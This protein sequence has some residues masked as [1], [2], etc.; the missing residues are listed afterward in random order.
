MFLLLFVF[1]LSVTL[2]SEMGQTDAEWL[3]R[4]DDIQ[5]LADA[6][7]KE[8]KRTSA[9]HLFD[10]IEIVR[11][12]EHKKTIAGYSRSLYLKMSIKSMHFK[13]EKAKEL[14][15]VLVLQHK[16]NGKYSFAIPEFPVMK[17]SYVHSMEEK[18]KMIH[19]QQRDAHFEEVKD[20]TIS[21]DFENQDYLP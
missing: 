5:Q 18:W 10:D 11:V 7:L 13:S 16:Q 3:S 6:A 2:C 9:I 20:Y 17:E 19:K 21:S 8:M 12:L 4:E 1:V 15:S 14:L